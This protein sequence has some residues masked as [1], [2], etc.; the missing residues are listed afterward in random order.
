MTDETKQSAVKWSPTSTQMLDLVQTRKAIRPI[1]GTTNVRD[2]EALG[3]MAPF[4]IVKRQ[5]DGVKGSL[6]FQ[7]SPRFYYSFEPK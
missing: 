1:W 6:M 7:N 5:S 3:F 2:F 4:V